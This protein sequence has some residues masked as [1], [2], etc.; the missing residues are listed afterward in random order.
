M[1]GAKESKDTADRGD[2]SASPLGVLARFL[3][4]RPL[5][6]GEG[7]SREIGEHRATIRLGLR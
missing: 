4:G 1:T 2:G 7:R 6:N 3:R 5:A